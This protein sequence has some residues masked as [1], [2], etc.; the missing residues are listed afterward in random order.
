[1]FNLSGDPVQK[2][3]IGDFCDKKSVEDDEPDYLVSEELQNK[4]LYIETMENMARYEISRNGDKYK[5]AKVAEPVLFKGIEYMKKSPV[6]LPTAEIDDSLV[7]DNLK[8]SD[9]MWSAYKSKL[10]VKDS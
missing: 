4:V 9:F 7:I 1:M 10:T 2:Y 6:P 8:W 5:I 3:T